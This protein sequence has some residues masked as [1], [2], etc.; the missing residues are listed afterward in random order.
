MIYM[1]YKSIAV[2]I[3]FHMNSVLKVHDIGMV[4]VIA[5]LIPRMKSYFI[6]FYFFF[7]FLLER[8]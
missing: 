4:N 7:S 5:I 3:P 1:S 6:L 8:W 2:I